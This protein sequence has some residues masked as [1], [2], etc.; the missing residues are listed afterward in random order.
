MYVQNFGVG[1]V[2]LLQLYEEQEHTIGLSVRCC[3]NTLI[4]S[5]E[6]PF[7]ATHGCTFRVP[8]LL[9]HVYHSY[10]C[11]VLCSV[12]CGEQETSTKP[13]SVRHL[14]P[15]VDHIYFTLVCA[16]GFK[17]CANVRDHV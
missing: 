11:C 8:Y 9:S 13:S 10:E 16:G 15:A 4:A 17:L 6:K 7:I 12:L 3:M 14:R 1:I 5:Q 2:V